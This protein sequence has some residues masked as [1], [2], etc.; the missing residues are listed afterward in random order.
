[1][2]TILNRVARWREDGI[3]SE[4]D[5]RQIEK[6][7]R[8][9]QMC[10]SKAVSVPGVKP[11]GDW[12]D[13]EEQELTLVEKTLFRAGV[14]R[15]NYLSTDRPDVAFT[16]KELC[17][18][19]SS[20]KPSDMMALKRVC[21]YLKGRGRLVQLI[22][23]VPR[24]GGDQW[25]LKVYVDSDWAGCRK[26]RKSTN[27]G[28]LVINGTCL[29]LWSSTQAVLALSSGEAEYYAALKGACIA[30]GFQSMARDL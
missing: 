18:C 10:G 25:N 8:D 30:L 6:L 12:E 27:G 4:A 19:M 5:P 22:P 24:D 3:R 23:T 20:P 14:A 2:I 29:R 7:L 1:M 28:C 17:R 11:S 21:R 15:F 26:T 9:L 16:V 13:A